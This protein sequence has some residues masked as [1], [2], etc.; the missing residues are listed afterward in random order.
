M[1]QPNHIQSTTWATSWQNIQK[2]LCAQRRS[3][4]SDQ[5]SLSAWRKVGSLATQWAHG[6]DSDQTLWMHRQIWVFAGCTCHAVAQ[7]SF[8][9]I[10]FKWEHHLPHL[11]Y[12][13]FFQSKFTCNNFGNLTYTFICLGVPFKIGDGL[14]WIPIKIWS[15]IKTTDCCFQTTS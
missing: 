12:I 5:S 1:S 8:F 15:F 4:Q 2:D 13:K 3:A 11:L 9:L 7:I 10:W 6:E 14:R